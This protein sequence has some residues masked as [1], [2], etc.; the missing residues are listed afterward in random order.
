MYKFTGNVEYTYTESPQANSIRWQIYFRDGDTF[1]AQTAAFKCKDYFNDICAKYNGSE[2]TAYGFDTSKM[3][4]NPEGVY[5]IVTGISDCAKFM[6]NVDTC[7]NKERPD[8]QITM[9][10][11]T[12][13]ILMFIPRYYFNQ[14]YLISLATYLIRISNNQE[15]F[16][17]LKQAMESTTAKSDKAVVGKGIILA[18]TWG[19]V[20]PEEYQK[21]WSYYNS[22]YNNTNYV[23]P[24]G[25][26]VHNCGVCNWSQTTVQEEV[27]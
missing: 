20:V 17:S 11:V 25:S 7:I 21:Y 24:I 27:V 4:L 2:V 13:G 23:K 18:K 6:D 1:T 15:S 10:L 16:S 8:D 3:K 19:L 14:S 22:R 26:M 9:E 12:G 5:V